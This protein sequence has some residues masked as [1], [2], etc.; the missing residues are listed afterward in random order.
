MGH[1]AGA[2]HP[3]LHDAV[4]GNAVGQGVS[5]VRILKCTRSIRIAQQAALCSRR[6]ARSWRFDMPAEI[7]QKSPYAVAVEAGKSY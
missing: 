4:G 1:E 2:A 5:A 6:A 7:A 3:A